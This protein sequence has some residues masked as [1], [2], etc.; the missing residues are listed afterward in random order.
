MCGSVANEKKIMWWRAKGGGRVD[1]K[2]VEEHSS[3]APADG[4]KG[5][6][7]SCVATPRTTCTW[8]AYVHPSNRLL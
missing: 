6:V 7:L 1:H 2:N 4:R 5:A 8:G 3:S